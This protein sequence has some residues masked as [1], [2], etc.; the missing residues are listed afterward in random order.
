MNFFYT[1]FEKLMKEFY[2]VTN[3]PHGL[4]DRDGNIISAVGS[5]DLCMKFHR[6]N[7]ESLKL[8]KQSDLS[9]KD[10]IDINKEYNVYV[11]KN[12]LV[13][14]VTPI[15]IEGEHIGAL[16]FGQ[17][18]FTEP[19]IDFFVILRLND[20]RNKTAVRHD[21]IKELKKVYDKNKIDISWP[22]RKVVMEK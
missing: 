19:N 5:Q 9:I 3:I 20:Y 8:C 21:F 11:C 12:G 1:F 4:I 18:F 16:I 17:F 22:V 7:P 15:I 2:N 13:E 6:M 10:R 14:A